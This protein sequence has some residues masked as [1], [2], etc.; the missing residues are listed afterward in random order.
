M[1]RSPHQKCMYNVAELGLKGEQSLQFFCSHFRIFQGPPHNPSYNWSS[2]NGAYHHHPA[3]YH[4]PHAQNSY[5]PPSH[6]YVSSAGDQLH[7]QRMAHHSRARNP[8]TGDYSTV[9][10]GGCL[11]QPT[12]SYQNLPSSAVENGAYL[13]EHADYAFSV[14]DF[15]G[16]FEDNVAKSSLHQL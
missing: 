1:R 9:P 12:N 15:Q 11:P 6:H 16:Q 13:Q 7:H 4:I 5:H 8:H 14:D 3:A 10:H 2:A